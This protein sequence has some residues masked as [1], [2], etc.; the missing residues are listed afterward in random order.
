MQSFS[1]HT[2]HDEAKDKDFELEIT[3][4]CEESKGKHVAVPKDIVEEA[5][6]LAKESIKSEMDDA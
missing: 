5:E 6:R 3:W 1:I 4:I 2:A